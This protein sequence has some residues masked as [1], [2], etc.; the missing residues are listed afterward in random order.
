VPKK[1][2][3]IKPYALFDFFLGSADLRAKNYLSP[4]MLT[5]GIPMDSKPLQR[6]FVGTGFIVGIKSF[7]FQPLIGLRIE[8]D[9]RTTTLAPG[10]TAN[11]AQL[12]NDLRYSWHAKLQVMIGFS[13]GDAKKVLGL[14]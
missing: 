6:P 9:Q 5:G 12:T 10:S 7:R 1:T 13:I 11:Q 14:K 4:L 8:K 2:N 3:N